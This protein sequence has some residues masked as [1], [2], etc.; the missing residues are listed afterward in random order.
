MSILDT[1]TLTAI[2]EPFQRFVSLSRDLDALSHSQQKDLSEAGFLRDCR[3]VES[4]TEEDCIT[5][6]S[7]RAVWSREILLM[8][9]ASAH[10]SNLLPQN[11]MCTPLS[12]LCL[13][14]QV[15]SPH[16]TP[17]VDAVLHTANRH[18]ARPV[19]QS[20]DLISLPMAISILLAWHRWAD[21]ARTCF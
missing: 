9:N 17:T 4:G 21:S 18:Y 13:I 20:D 19:S 10:I 5:C 6:V 16:R 12:Q 7:L 8:G 15:C 1:K 11:T 14:V 2:S 3:V